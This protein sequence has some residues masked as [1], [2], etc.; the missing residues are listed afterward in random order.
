MLEATF[1]HSNFLKT[2]FFSFVFD[3][4]FSDKTELRNVLTGNRLLLCCQAAWTPRNSQHI[5]LTWTGGATNYKKEATLTIW[6]Y[7]MSA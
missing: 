6:K 7:P 4:Q 5:T 3:F 2:F 1:L